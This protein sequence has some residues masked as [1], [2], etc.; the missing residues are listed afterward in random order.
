MSK[1]KTLPKNEKEL[2]DELCN[3]EIDHY[4]NISSRGDGK[5]FATKRIHQFYH[6]RK[7]QK[8]DDT[9]I[10]IDDFPF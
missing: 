4:I 8:S 2:L 7:E 3:D 5:S 10:D 9:D 1:K 6:F